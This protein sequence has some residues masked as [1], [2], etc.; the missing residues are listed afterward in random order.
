VGH[1]FMKAMMAEK[2]AIFG[3]ELS[4][5]FYFR[6]NFNADSGAI[7]MCTVLTML[8]STG[9]KMSS[10]VAPAKRY[11]QSGEINFTIEDKDGALSN[12]RKAALAWSP[13]AHVDELDGVTIDAFDRPLTQ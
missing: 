9:K 3:G 1:V 8:K 5:H 6:N 10:L 2:N 4:G 13:G 12:L 7:A 11:V